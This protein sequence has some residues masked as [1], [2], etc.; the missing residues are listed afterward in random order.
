M[1]VNFCIHG[2]KS[3][4]YFNCKREAPH[5]KNIIRWNN[6]QTLNLEEARRYRK[7]RKPQASNVVC[8]KPASRLER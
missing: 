5:D 1:N 7:H 3:E 6:H 8:A 4:N 2:R